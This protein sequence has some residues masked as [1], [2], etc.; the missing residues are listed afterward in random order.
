MEGF[1]FDPG[2]ERCR[3]CETSAHR[4][5][6]TTLLAAPAPGAET[7]ILWIGEHPG[8]E[9]VQQRQ[10]FVG[11][12][13]R[14]LRQVIVPWVS[15]KTTQPID[16][17]GTNGVRCSPPVGGHPTQSQLETC[18]EYLEEDIRVL[19][20]RYRRVVLVACGSHA[21]WTLTGRSM[22]ANLRHQGTPTTTL[23]AGEWP[24]FFTHNP[25]ILLPGRNPSLIRNVE[26]HLSIL[27]EWLNTGK[28]P[29]SIEVPTGAGPVGSLPPDL[30][31]PVVVAVDL[32]TYGSVMGF[33]EQ[34]VFHPAKSVLVD[35]V[36]RDRL[37]V[38][39]AAAW[40]R[41]GKLES[42]VWSLPRE[43]PLFETFMEDVVGRG[44][45][46]LGQNV[47]FDIMYMRVY[48]ERLW[49]LL[50]R[51]RFAETGS[52]LREL[53]VANFLENDTREEKSLKELAPLLGVLNYE[54][55][56]S[57]GDGWRYPSPDDPELLQY[58]VL[59]ATATLACW[60][61]LEFRARQ[62]WP[63]S[64]KFQDC[65]LDWFNDLLWAVLGM[66]EAGIH[67]NRVMLE[68]LR[69]KYR[70]K[71]LRMARYAWRRWLLPIEGEGSAGFGREAVEEAV[72][73]AGLVGDRR[74]ERTKGP[75]HSICVN[76]SNI[77]LLLGYLGPRSPEAMRLRYLLHFKKLKK[78]LTS[79]LE[80]LLEEPREGLIRNHAFPTWFVTPSYESDEGGRRGGTQ[81]GRLTCKCP[82]KQT[83]PP[84]IY[85]TECSRWRGGC[86]LKPDLS[87]IELRIMALLSGDPVMMREYV[88]GVDRHAETGILILT[89]I[90]SM[91]EARGLTEYC[92]VALKDVVRMLE[93]PP[94]ES[95]E[96][97]GKWRQM[98]K[99]VNFAIGFKA[100]ATT[101][102]RSIRRDMRVELDGQFCGRLIHDCYQKYRRLAEWQDELMDT[103]RK[104]GSIIIPITGESRTFL[105]GPRAIDE[106]YAATICNFPVQT[107]ASR[108]LQSAQI[109]VAKGL[110]EARSVVYDNVYD[111]FGVDVYPGER[112][113]VEELLSRHLV[114]P[115]FYRMLCDRL[116]RSVPLAYKVKVV[117]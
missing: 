62:R 56:A 36:P 45:D 85:G 72:L 86:L 46:V 111:A 48:S 95:T 9:E 57:L 22:T 24:V 68:R 112:P 1:R 84:E 87:Q 28:L 73:A 12:S 58:C 3:L 55:V 110:E 27:T 31:A 91:M 70:R 51:A 8:V 4:C 37:V 23:R 59:D 6:P 83:F 2:C 39:A 50:R 20:S 104:T 99:T 116:G 89:A 106:T 42:A 117:A 69:G 67:F 19:G 103:A 14:I 65:C 74:L 96:G 60:E 115:P 44:G 64:D 43:L 18:R 80:P 94:S 105:G 54:G 11:P 26:D 25:A 38:C 107:V 114:N 88:E 52:R 79:Y 41:H 109:E 100:T 13:G 53:G 98:G 78:V 93:G 63:A 113:L 15:R 47:C 81:Q 40:R 33:P 90:R 30:E 71:Y 5:I 102:Q 16:H 82:A 29:Q 66:D 32:E 7:A 61:V 108:V 76:E 10:S 34:T 75:A 49:K 97:F 77:N 101:L 35:G 92:G 21:S 17:Y